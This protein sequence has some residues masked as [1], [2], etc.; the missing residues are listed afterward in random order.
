MKMKRY[1]I[2]CLLA[3][4]G[5]LMTSCGDYL[6]IV[7]DNVISLEE[8]FK[9]RKGAEEFLN[10]AY[11]TLPREWDPT[12]GCAAICDEMDFPWAEYEENSIN[13]GGMSPSKGWRQ[14]WG[15]YY[16]AIRTAAT[17]I[18]HIDMCQDV[19]ITDKLKAQYKAEARFLRAYYYFCIF[20]WYGPFV[21]MPEVE[22]DVGGS[23]DEM[24]IPRSS[25]DECVQYIYNELE[26]ACN[27]GLPDWYE[28][29]TDYGRATITAA[30]AIQSRLLL[31]AAS[32]LYNGNTDYANFK[33][34]DGN[35]LVN[36]TY[37]DKKWQDAAKASKAFIDRYTDR[38]A[39]YTENKEDGSIDPYASY[40]QLF[41]TGW[42]NEIIW[43]R[44]NCSFWSFEANAP[45]FC[46][47]WS[48][49]DPTQ[50]IV[51]DYF[52]SKGLPISDEPYADKDPDYTT[53]GTCATT[54]GYAP[55]GT[56][57]MYV[58]RES[59]FYVS[60][61]F[62]NSKWVATKNA[63]TCEL[64]FGGNT[65]HTGKTRNY[66]TTGYILRKYS[67]PS[68]DWKNS[69]NVSNRQQALFRLA[70]I[71]LNYAEA[72][73]ECE[74]RDVDE[75]LKYVNKVRERAGLP[76][77]GDGPEFIMLKSK[78]K[79]AIRE[80]IRRERRI[81]LAFENHRFYDVRRWKIM[82][83][84]DKCIY[85]LNISATRP[86]F[87]QVIKTEDRPHDFK[88]YLWPIPQ[89]EIYKNKRLVQNPGWQAID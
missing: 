31:Y 86:L 24:S 54:I 44:N 13:E 36:Q 32:P 40:Q 58:N 33:D 9:T 27:E 89:S 4:S 55:K 78:E 35:Q 47:G 63:A 81:E 53:E 3:G 64:Y 38:F 66:S 79:E 1:I 70:E 45:R 14:K 43:A 15:G 61:C 80:L 72:L 76:G 82:E 7:P 22:V 57:N 30:R 56:S 17:F 69:Q 87:Y 52:T 75:V 5:A 74:A 50:N 25:V 2:A 67:N 49:W 60:I 16:K 12:D 73:N 42:N 37:S 39:L 51:D 46:N 20:R 28:E 48:G 34:Q 83:E 29:S 26:K 71:Y 85:G 6:D 65:G 19:N 84:T 8:I 77:Y 18:S 21:I 62:D 59:R 68:V 88:Y 10:T 41:L 23:I 11:A